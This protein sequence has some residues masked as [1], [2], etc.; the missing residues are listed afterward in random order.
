M[1]RRYSKLRFWGVAAISAG[2]FAA[3]CGSGEQADGSIRLM[4]RAPVQMPFHGPGGPGT[5]PMYIAFNWTVAVAAAEGADSVVGRVRTRLTER[6]SGAV[7]TADG[8]AVGSLGAGAEV[9]LRQQA[10]GPFPSSLYPGDWLGVTT[11][12]VSH[13]SGRLETVSTS[14]TFR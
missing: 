14:F 2:L 9:E 6:A 13:R 4:I 5:E 10:S 1:M 3:A 12:E 8:D 7:L 11:V